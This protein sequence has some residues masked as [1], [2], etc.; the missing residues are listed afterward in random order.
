[1]CVAGPAAVLRASAGRAP[2]A[3]GL[4]FLPDG[5]ACY[6]ALVRRY[7]TLA[8]TPDQVHQA[9]LDAIAAVHQEFSQLG[10]GTVGSSDLQE[11]F[12]A[13]REDPSLRFE[14]AEQVED[15]ARV[16]L[17]EANAAVPAAF[18]RLPDAPCEV[19]PI[20][21]HEAPYT[22]IAYYQP[23]EPGG[24]RPGVYYIN[25]HAPDTRPRFEARALAVHEAVPGHHF[26]ISI[27]QELPALPAFRK[28]AGMTA[29]VEG[30]ALYTE[31]LADELGLYPTDVDR[32]GM[33]SFDAWQHGSWSI[34]AYTTWA[35]HGP[36]QKTDAG[37]HPA[38]GQQYRQRGR[39]ICVL[40]RRPWP[41]RQGN[42]RS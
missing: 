19:R 14:T 11:I 15:A 40:A 29:F 3:A 31:R 5:E 30:W 2:E 32:L 18:G 28:H 23:S 39:S 4:R 21:A 38:G 16:A 10:P 20:P 42:W 36:R 35:G 7:T 26:Q 37:E 17:A 41:T 12:R 13:L 34:R 22:T 1:M 27:A 9:G 24:G 8:R 6:A 25:T 33:L